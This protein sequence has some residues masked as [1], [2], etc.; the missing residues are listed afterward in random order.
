LS[1]KHVP[2][3]VAFALVLALPAGLGAAEVAQ[4]QASPQ[5]IYAAFSLLKQGKL[6]MKRCGGYSITTGTYTGRSSSPDA[7]LAGSVT[8]TGRISVH[9][10][11]TTGVATG[12][13]TVRDSLRRLRTRASINGVITE[14][15]EVNGNVVGWVYDP[16][17]R[18]LANLTMVFDDELGFAAVRLGLETGK[19]SGIA[20]P[21][22]PKCR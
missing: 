12:T 3:A 6:T 9:P 18:L 11:G 7:R 20:Y 15:S 10:G 16:T 5:P 22:I 2:I 13:L 4:T 17:A 1:N 8:Y 19:N 21:T 14:R